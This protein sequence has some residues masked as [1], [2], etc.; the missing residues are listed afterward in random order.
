MKKDQNIEILN[1]SRTLETLSRE[2]KFLR[3]HVTSEQVV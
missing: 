1:S 3:D 2:M